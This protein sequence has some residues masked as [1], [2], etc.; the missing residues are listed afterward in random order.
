MGPVRGL[1]HRGLETVDLRVG[2]EPA[3]H[4]LDP[5]E[6]P[7]EDGGGRRYRPRVVTT[8]SIEVDHRSVR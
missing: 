2:P 5:V 6:L 7:L 8:N 3:G 1:G 4:L